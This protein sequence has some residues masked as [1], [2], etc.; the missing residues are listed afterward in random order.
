M[1]LPGVGLESVVPSYKCKSTQLDKQLAITIEQRS[2]WWLRLLPVQIA[3]AIALLNTKNSLPRK[4]INCVQPLVIWAFA[5][6]Q[7]IFN[8]L[9]HGSIGVVT[10]SDQK[11]DVAS[12][13]EFVIWW[14]DVIKSCVFNSLI[15]QDLKPTKW[16]TRLSCCF[17]YSIQFWQIY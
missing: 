3:E 1:S 11:Y 15:S 6:S 8:I 10:L 7:W 5:F 12:T 17:A 4:T 14:R 16:H 9:S 2:C 13:D